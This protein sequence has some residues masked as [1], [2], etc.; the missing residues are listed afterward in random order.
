M[1]VSGVNNVVAVETS[2]E[3][4]YVLTAAGRVF[5][6][7]GVTREDYVG[8][9]W[10]EVPAGA[11]GRGARLTAISATVCDSLYGVD[12]AGRICQLLREDVAMRRPP[13]AAARQR[14]WPRVKSQC[15]NEDEEEG[16]WAVV[17]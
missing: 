14:S 5:R 11:D 13:P 16:G 10:R 6:R 2:D 9:G 15:D 1:P 8:T 3:A 7:C 17:E 12:R 4:A